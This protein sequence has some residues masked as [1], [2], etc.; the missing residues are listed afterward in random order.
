MLVSR[1]TRVPASGRSVRSRCVNDLRQPHPPETASADKAADIKPDDRTRP[2]H[3][4]KACA[5]IA[6]T[7]VCS[8]KTARATVTAA[9]VHAPCRRSQCMQIL[10]LIQQASLAQHHRSLKLA[11]LPCQSLSCASPERFSPFPAPHALA[12]CD[13]VCVAGDLRGT[14]AFGACASVWHTRIAECSAD[15]ERRSASHPGQR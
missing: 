11:D 7:M 14:R 4:L 12:L 1:A 10:A 15:A 5:S 8:A 9:C 2:R 6:R 3:R 13:V